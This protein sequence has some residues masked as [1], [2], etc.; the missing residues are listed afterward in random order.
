MH[1]N[2]KSHNEVSSASL[3]HPEEA[4]PGDSNLAQNI[5]DRYGHSPGV[6][7]TAVTLGLA[8]R[9][10]RLSTGLTPVLADIQTRWSI[11]DGSFSHGW[12]ELPYAWPVGP[13]DRLSTSTNVASPLFATRMPRFAQA[14]A[15]P[16]S[17]R[18]IGPQPVASAL[19]AKGRASPDHQAVERPLHRTVG[20]GALKA[21]R[22]LLYRS[23]GRKVPLS[24][25]ARN[26]MSV[27]TGR[28]VGPSILP[29]G[30]VPMLHRAA[31][32]NQPVRET[33]TEVSI[34]TSTGESGGAMFSSHLN[35]PAGP[36]IQ[37]KAASV[38]PGPPDGGGPKGSSRVGRSP[39]S[40]GDG[41]SKV[42]SGAGLSQYPVEVGE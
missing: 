12:S 14:N 42:G 9:I 37:G 15:V 36:A 35:G 33:Q 2:E 30:E 29:A 19:A 7:P 1:R 8:K 24:A 13:A 10:T 34:A 25:E 32:E 20:S 5:W 21:E 41:T 23:S 6:I 18:L 3:S 17:A 38:K 27:V 4:L 31:A 11:T 22:A 39:V 40:Q 16:A 26:S 28:K